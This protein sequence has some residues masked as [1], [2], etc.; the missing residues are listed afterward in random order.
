MLL[1]ANS[2]RSII[3]SY[4]ILCETFYATILFQKKYLNCCC[5]HYPIDYETAGL[6]LEF[7]VFA[8]GWRVGN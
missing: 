1:K 8:F 6:E 3:T 2:P 7:Q 5:E 4:E